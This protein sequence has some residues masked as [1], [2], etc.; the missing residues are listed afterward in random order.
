MKP[1]P[2]QIEKLPKWTQEYIKDLER[3]RENA[4]RALNEY[5]DNQTPAPFSVREYESTGEG[6]GPSR[7]VRYIQADRME[8]QWQGVSLEIIL[9]EDNIDLQ[10]RGASIMEDCAFIPR[11]YQQAALKSRNKMR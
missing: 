7:K 5:C 3:Q 1:T 10:W 11:S 8:I 2:E 9:R 4:I 6:F